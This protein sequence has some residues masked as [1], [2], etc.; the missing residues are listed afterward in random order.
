[1]L[2][3]HDREVWLDVLLPSS[4]PLWVNDISLASAWLGRAWCDALLDLGVGE[5]SGQVAV[6]EG[7][8]EHNELSSLVCFA[9]RAPGEVFIGR[10]KAV[11]ISQRRTR[12]WVRFQCALSLRWEPDTMAAVVADS[13]VTVERLSGL[14]TD[15]DL[16]VS[17][18][19]DAVQQRI[20]ERLA[21]R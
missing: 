3:G 19:V 11:G 5:A 1:M 2:V 6:H 15:L 7:P 18:V 16:A 9:G 10:S 12:D 21:A 8:M 17:D 20:T 13:S 4:H 14:G